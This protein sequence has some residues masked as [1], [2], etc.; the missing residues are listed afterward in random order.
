MRRRERTV[1]AR[2]RRYAYR[3]ACVGTIVTAVGFA[4]LVR[5][6][7]LAAFMGLCAGLMGFART[8][9][10]RGKQH[11]GQAP[12]PPVEVVLPAGRPTATTAL[13]AEGHRAFARALH[14]VTTA[15]LAECE[16]EP[17]R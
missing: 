14:A 3:G 13:A 1:G 6:A 4:G 15:Y 10:R 7:L 5:V 17:G 16:R 11:R 12:R 8:E 2:L 9:V